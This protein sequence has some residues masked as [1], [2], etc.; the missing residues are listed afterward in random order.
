[1]LDFH[2]HL[3][4]GVD[5]GSKN[6][7]MSV[8]MLDMWKEQGF[9]HVCATPHFYADMMSPARFLEKRN[10]AYDSLISALDTSYGGAANYPSILLGA[11]V[12]YFRGM[13][14]CEDI[15]RLCLQNTK[16]I[17]VEM[18]FSKWS[19]YMIREVSELSNLG[20]I[21]VA[22][23]IERYMSIQ[24][25]KKIDELLNTGILVQCNAEF[26][27]SGITKRKALRMVSSHTIDFLGSDAHNTAGRAPNLGEAVNFITKKLGPDSLSHI[28]KNNSL[29]IDASR[30][31]MMGG[32]AV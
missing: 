22:A 2:S 29:V 24:G 23:H 4:P 26:F 6:I 30:M 25:S 13:S 10:E 16:L 19:D 21:P 28:E 8:A 18:P 5:D 12:Y 20:L 17:L 31:A 32:A 3:I 9:S 27:L 7:E 11:E 1:M 14:T 15:S